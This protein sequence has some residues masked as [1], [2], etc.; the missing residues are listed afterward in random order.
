MTYVPFPDNT[1]PTPAQP[2]VIPW[3]KCP[4]CNGHG[5]VFNDGIS[6]S[7]TSVCSVCNGRKIIPMGIANVPK[8]FRNF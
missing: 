8:K 6:S 7:I 3:Q 2:V 5:Y 4:I 1:N